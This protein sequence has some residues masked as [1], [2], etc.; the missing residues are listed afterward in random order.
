MAARSCRVDQER[1]DAL[2]PPKQRDVNDVGAALSEELFEVAI[3][4]PEAENRN[5]P[6]RG[7][8]EGRR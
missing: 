2:H 8:I 5:P 4:Q 6:K 7:Q 1:R 3:R